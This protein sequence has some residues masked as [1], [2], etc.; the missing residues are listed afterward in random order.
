MPDTIFL[1]TF[2]S[3]TTETR[4]D[5]LQLAP[6]WAVGKTLPSE[7]PKAGP[8][9][10]SQRIKDLSGSSPPEKRSIENLHLS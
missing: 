5:H 3:S 1:A 6:G 4:S 9:S 10:R 8:S 2:R 7:G